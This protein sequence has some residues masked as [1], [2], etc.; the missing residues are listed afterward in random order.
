MAMSPR[1]LVLQ[2]VLVEFLIEF[3]LPHVQQRFEPHYVLSLERRLPNLVGDHKIR[4][5]CG[6]VRLALVLRVLPVPSQPALRPSPV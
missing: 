6:S 1:A 4:G 5:L 2:P 3:A